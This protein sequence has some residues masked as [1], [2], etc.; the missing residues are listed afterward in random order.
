LA[1]RAGRIAGFS[2]SLLLALAAAPG[3]A[4]AQSSAQEAR[5]AAGNEAYE[6]G[7]FEEAI[8]IYEELQAA[9]VRSSALHYNLGNALFKTSRMGRAIL[10]YERAL[11]LDPSDPDVRDNLKYL[12]SLTI[13]RI[14]PESSP[15]TALGIAYLL[16][17]TS[18]N[19]DALLFLASWIAAGLAVGVSMAA[20]REHVRRLALYTAGA[21][22]LPV[23][24]SGG[25]LALK[26][27]LAAT[28]TYGIVLDPQVN[29][30]SGA[31][32]ENPVLFTIHEGLKVQVRNASNGWVQVSLADGLSGWLPGSALEEI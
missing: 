3:T 10:E 29:V 5:F 24:V 23:L 6:S 27:Y 12:R 4:H 14:E 7:A 18:P 21:L 2:L 31:G 13:D 9:G 11:R 32:E 28:S 26:S 25:N 19:Q 22:L 16:E 17:L 20:R 30:L 15:L 1:R 8:V